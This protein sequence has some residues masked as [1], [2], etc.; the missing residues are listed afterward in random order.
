M[1][2]MSRFVAK[3]CMLQPHD[4][5]YRQNYLL[6][7]KEA[8]NPFVISSSAPLSRF[9]FRLI[10]L[11]PFSDYRMEYAPSDCR[12]TPRDRAQFVESYSKLLPF[13]PTVTGKWVNHPV[14]LQHAP[15]LYG[16]KWLCKSVYLD[17]VLYMLSYTKYL[18]C[19]DLNAD[20]LNPRVVKLPNKG[21]A[22]GVGFI[23]MSKDC[24]YYSNHV[25][26][27]ILV[28]SLD[29]DHQWILKHSIC[30][31]DLVWFHHGRILD[32]YRLSPLLVPCALHPSSEVIFIAIPRLIFSYNL[33]TNQFN[34]FYI[35]N[36]Q[37]SPTTPE[38]KQEHFKALVSQAATPFL[39]GRTNR[40]VNEVE[41]FLALGLNIE[42]YDKVYMQHLGWKVSGITTEEREV[43]GNAPLVPYLFLFGED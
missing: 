18:L 20:N 30:I 15:E 32:R 10:P 13:Q 2:S 24:F 11:P 37:K 27:A 31:D 8:S 12:R 29:H 9:P 3:D 34:V 21:K 22:L 36:D 26:N 6:T 4:A 16:F 43:S 1:V 40:F 5:L 41:L 17:G 35:L 14:P 23:G 42:A 33:K 7:C 39:I 38:T 19:F 25:E 28:W